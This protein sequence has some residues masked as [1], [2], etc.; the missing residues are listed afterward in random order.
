MMSRRSSC[1]IEGKGPADWAGAMAQIGTAAKDAG[2]RV[3]IADSAA[4]PSLADGSVVAGC[5]DVLVEAVGELVVELVDPEVCSSPESRQAVANNTATAPA[6][7]VLRVCAEGGLKSSILA[8]LPDSSLAWR[9]P[10]CHDRCL[11]DLHVGRPA[12]QKA[13]HN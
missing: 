2:L 7:N 5:A 9:G 12:E 11:N 13:G 10:G 6:R 4:S 8:R 1:S 3:A